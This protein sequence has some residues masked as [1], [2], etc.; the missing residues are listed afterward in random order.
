VLLEEVKDL[1]LWWS[2]H[3]GQFSIIARLVK[4]ILSIPSSEIKIENIL[5]CMYFHK[6]SILLPWSKNLNL[7]ILF[8]KNMLMIPQL[9]LKLSE[10][11]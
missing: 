2:K 1:L 9:D 7:L 8:I 3:E 4:A 10:D 5:G 6:S 11:H